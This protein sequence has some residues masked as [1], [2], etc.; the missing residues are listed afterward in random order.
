MVKPVHPGLTNT[1]SG[2]FGIDEEG[3]LAM[4]VHSGHKPNVCVAG[5]T[6]PV[7][8]AQAPHVEAEFAIAPIMYREEDRAMER[9]QED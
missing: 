9:A 5:G 2:K 4:G 6:N 7:K 1:Y 8:T 3:R